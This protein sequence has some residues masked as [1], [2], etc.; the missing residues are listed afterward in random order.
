M[1]QE[2]E[3][4]YIASDIDIFDVHS[5]KLGKIGNIVYQEK[6]RL[7]CFLPIENFFYKPVHLALII[8]KLNDLNDYKKEVKK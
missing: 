2:I 5:K 8:K 4:S 1:E 3:L 6:I 7:W